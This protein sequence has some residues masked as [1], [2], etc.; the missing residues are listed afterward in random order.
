MNKKLFLLF[1]IVLALVFAPK[2]YAESLVCEI[3]SHMG[4]CEATLEAGK[5]TV[6]VTL[7]S[8]Q[9]TFGTPAVV[10]GSVTQE[11]EFEGSIVTSPDGKTKTYVITNATA[12]SKI[13]SG[14]HYLKYIV[15]APECP[16][17]DGT[18]TVEPSGEVE[19]Q[20][21]VTVRP[22]P[23]DCFEVDNVVIKGVT[24]G[25]SYTPEAKENGTY[26]FLMPGEAVKITVHFKAKANCS[27]TPTPTATPTATP[28]TT[29]TPTA[30]PAPGDVKVPDTDTYSY[31]TTFITLLI[32]SSV[33]FVLYKK[34]S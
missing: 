34:V 8:N 20:A 16:D 23:K 6:V 22:A 24:S 15:T 11:A 33:G 2:V 18:A 1:V 28:S 21:L 5:T 9:A 12:T 3:D 27:A 13:N 31:L 7:T 32:I 25:S 14:V 10:N 29:A 17:G 4:T 26:T 19:Y 30:S